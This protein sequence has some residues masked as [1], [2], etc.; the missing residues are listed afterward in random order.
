[1]NPRSTIKPRQLLTFLL[2]VLIPLPAI[3]HDYPIFLLSCLLSFIIT[4]IYPIINAIIFFDSN[5][6]IW[7][8]PVVYTV[9][10]VIVTLWIYVWSGGPAGDQFLFVLPFLCLLAIGW[11]VIWTLI[12]KLVRKKSS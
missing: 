7:S 3:I 9:M 10:A 1:M 6:F 12:V 5:V 4:I 11:S 2:P 8:A